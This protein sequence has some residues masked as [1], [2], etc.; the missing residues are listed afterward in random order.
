VGPRRFDVGDGFGGSTSQ[1]VR[2]EVSD[3]HYTLGLISLWR[4]KKDQGAR[5]A[6]THSRR[7]SAD[8]RLAPELGQLG[9]AIECQSSTRLL[10]FG[11]QAL[12][13]RLDVI[14]IFVVHAAIPMVAA[15]RFRMR[16]R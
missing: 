1:E 9:I 12:V 5:L 7:A 6:T 2:G 16:V 4:A 8:D 10:H 11:K 14:R 15:L 13:D 3:A